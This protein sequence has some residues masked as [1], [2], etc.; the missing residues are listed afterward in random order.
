MQLTWTEQKY[1][2]IKISF[3]FLLEKYFILFYI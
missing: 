3:T 2:N 1:F